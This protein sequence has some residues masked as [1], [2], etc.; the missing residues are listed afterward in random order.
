[1]KHKHK[2]LAATVLTLVAGSF[3][4]SAAVWTMTSG[5]NGACNAAAPSSGCFGNARSFAAD[6]G[7]APS[8]SATAWSNTAGTSNTGLESAF[9]S[10]WGAS[11]LGVT[12][13]DYTG[14]GADLNEG[15][16]PEHSL[17]NNGRFDSVLLS[18]G[19]DKIALESVDF[20]WAS[21]T[22]GYDTDFTVLYYDGTGTP[23]LAGQTYTGLLG[24]AS[25]ASGGWKLLSSY[26]AGN[27]TS[28]PAAVSLGN[29]GATAKKSSYWLVSSYNSALG[30]AAGADMYDDYMKFAAISGSVV[31]PP[32]VPEPGTMALTLLGLGLLGHRRGWSVLQRR[33]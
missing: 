20:G 2:T 7:T 25:G 28:N 5:T 16:S 9:L 14:T 15:V 32:A 30:S 21:A 33:A 3:N 27:G 19:S 18:F 26:N 22:G 4:A 12:N 24:A 11:G 17:D 31:R 10:I 8:V 23:N 29:T 1:M 13:R 6:V